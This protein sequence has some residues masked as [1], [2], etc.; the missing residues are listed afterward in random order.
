MFNGISSAEGHCV[1]ESF[2]GIRCSAPGNACVHFFKLLHNLGIAQRLAYRRCF[3]V[4]FIAISSSIYTI[5]SQS[6]IAH[7]AM[8][9]QC[10]KK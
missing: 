8:Y 3:W 6:I 1:Y 10:D 4:C 9:P 5:T 2:H 7:L